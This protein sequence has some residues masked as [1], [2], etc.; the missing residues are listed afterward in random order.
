MD[1]GDKWYSYAARI[2]E[3]HTGRNG[4]S[5]DQI[6]VV[7]PDYLLMNDIT[8]LLT[9]RILEKTGA[10]AK[11]DCRRV[12]TIISFDHYAPAPTADIATSHARMRKYARQWGCTLYDVGDG[13][14]HQ[15]AVEDHMAPGVLALGADSHTITYGA[16]GAFSSGIGSTEA[17]YIMVY[18]SIWLKVPRVVDYVLEGKLEEPLTGKDLVLHILGIEGGDGLIYRSAEFTG[19]GLSSIPIPDRLTVANMMVEAGAK[20]GIFPSDA[21]LRRWMDETRGGYRERVPLP[22]KPVD[23]RG[24]A[25]FIDLGS[26]EPMVSK[27]HAPYNV[28]SI[29]EVEGTE[30]D[31]VFIG[32][33]TNGRLEDLVAAARIIG[34]H[35]I[36]RGV[37]VIVTPASR[38]V[39]NKAL[40]MGVLQKLHQA[41]AVIAV[42]GCGACFGAHLG[43]VGE[44]E[45]MLS[46]SNRNFP[47]RMGSPKAEVYL[48]SPYTAGATAAEG[49]IADPRRY[50]KPGN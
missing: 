20:T 3:A 10:V 6:V 19:P 28:A 35:G 42:P 17:A 23:G 33:C 21:V 30:V 18:G 12:P 36:R 48:A 50:I 8:F 49:K 31:Q 9:L 7:K 43:V 47:G 14:M 15:L 44:G 29:G 5:E 38:R 37:R 16:V 41:G 40:E 2:L 34:K 27:P 4:L 32:S 13:I 25:R 22:P 1:G 24:D 46:T 39:Y 11:A 26:L 45:V